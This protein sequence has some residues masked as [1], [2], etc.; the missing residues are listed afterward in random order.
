VKVVGINDSV[1]LFQFMTDPAMIAANVL[2]SYDAALTR[3]ESH[4]LKGSI[5]LLK[6][7]QESPAGRADG[8]TR[9]LAARIETLALEG[10]KEFTPVFELTSK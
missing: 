6:A 1:E 4:D 10:G 7:L 9:Q 3:F 2:S 5:E 8:P